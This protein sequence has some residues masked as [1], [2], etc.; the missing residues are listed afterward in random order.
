LQSSDVSADGASDASELLNDAYRMLLAYYPPIESHAL[1]VQE[2]AGA[3][4]PECALFATVNMDTAAGARLISERQGNWT[5]TLRIIEVGLSSALLGGVRSLCFSPD[6]TQ[7]VSASRS[8]YRAIELWS[9]RTGA[10]LA[11]LEMAEIHNLISEQAKTCDQTAW[12][13]D[14]CVAY[15]SDGSRIVSS[16]ASFSSDF[17]VW[18]ALWDT[19]TYQQLAVLRDPRDS[20]GQPITGFLPVS[21]LPGSSLVVFGCDDGTICVWDLAAN[22]ATLSSGGNTTSKVR[23]IACSPDGSKIVSGLANGLLRVWDSRTGD[24]LATLEGHSESVNSVA[25]SPNGAQLVS[26]SDDWSIR[27][28]DMRMN[29]VISVLRSHGYPVINV[30]PSHAVTSVAFSPDGRQVVSGSMDNTVRIWDVQSTK[31]ITLLQGHHEG[32]LSVS[33]SPDAALVASGSADGTIRVWDIQAPPRSMELLDDSNS[34]PTEELVISLNGARLVSTAGKLGRV[35]DMST[36][37]EIAVLDGHTG[38]IWVVAFSPDSNGLRIVTG[39]GDKTVRV[40]N[41]Q[42]GQQLARFSV[43]DTP[44]AVA[45]LADGTRVVAGLNNGKMPVWDVSTGEQLALLVEPQD[46]LSAVAL[47]PG[48]SRVVSCSDYGPARLWDVASGDHVAVIGSLDYIISSVA[49]SPDGSRVVSSSYEGLFKA[50]DTITGA[51][52]AIAL[53]EELNYSVTVVA[54]SYKGDP[55]FNSEGRE[56]RITCDCGDI[57]MSRTPRFTDVYAKQST[58]SRIG[59]ADLGPMGNHA[60]SRIGEADLSPM[61]NHALSAITWD[62][63]TGWLSCRSVSNKL[64]PLCWLPV[65]RRGPAMICGRMVAVGGTGGKVT[66]LDLTEAIE[67]LHNEGIV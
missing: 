2:S 47:S 32:V 12:I 53:A 7:L 54:Y 27:I 6:G 34:K 10:Q 24:G 13:S 14:P 8:Y 58:A 23:A 36:G 19:K 42:T 52:I 46:I 45:L 18:L 49:F 66:M 65:E 17:I 5:A 56:L 48:G 38:I 59:E 4:M 3:T 1:H 63:S 57:M 35:W 33:F 62:K 31:Q 55:L 67:R 39:S 25:F 9:V 51:Y 22:T 26:G 11:V 20:M 41:T 64:F 50:W 30:I 44:R 60:A 37:Q 61:G 15:S 16:F 29:E 40:W 28:W 21:F 43:N